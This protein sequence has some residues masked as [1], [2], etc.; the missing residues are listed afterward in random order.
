MRKYPLLITGLLL[1]TM[2][3]GIYF[4]ANQLD[5]IE[6]MS[7]TMEEVDWY[8]ADNICSQAGS[9]WTLPSISQLIGLFYFNPDAS[10]NRA[11][12]YWSETR[13][14]NYGFGLNTRLGI[15]SFDVLHDQDHFICVRD[16]QLLVIR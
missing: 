13:I 16:K 11:T 4:W 8:H 12:D 10:W 5:R 3:A 9:G 15:L 2:I 6:V 14:N 7:F 1:C